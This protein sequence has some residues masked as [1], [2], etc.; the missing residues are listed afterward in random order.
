MIVCMCLFNNLLA[1]L[2]AEMFVSSDCFL[3]IVSSQAPSLQFSYDVYSCQL[4]L[5]DTTSG[6]VCSVPI[7]YAQGYGTPVE[8]S[9]NPPFH[10]SYQCSF[11]LISSYTYVFIV[12]YILTGFGETIARFLLFTS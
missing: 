2:L 9:I 10:Y 8:V 5:A 12:R 11:S 1:P 3:Y 4:E 6:E 7:L